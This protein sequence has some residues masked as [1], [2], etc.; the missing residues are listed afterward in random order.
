MM[1]VIPRFDLS[2][3]LVLFINIIKIMPCTFVF[4]LL[5]IGFMYKEHLLNSTLLFMYF[6]HLL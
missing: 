5:G 6:I 3:V 4:P 1:C 2:L